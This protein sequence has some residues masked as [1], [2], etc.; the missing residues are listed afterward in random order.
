MRVTVLVLLGLVAG[1]AGSLQRAQEMRANAPDWYEAR[2]EELFSKSYPKI[3]D[4]PEQLNLRPQRERLSLSKEET[5]AALDFF[6]NHPRA[7]LSEETPEEMLAWAADV[8]RATEGRL[9]PPDFLTDEDVAALRAVFDRPR[10][11]L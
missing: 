7:A 5:Q 4:V 8:R 3:S 10:G 2:K 1:C 6:I 9:P 11:R